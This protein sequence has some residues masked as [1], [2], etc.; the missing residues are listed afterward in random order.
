LTARL[1][2]NALSEKMIKDD[3]SRVEESATKSK[4]NWVLVLRDVRT[5]MRV[6]LLTL[7][8]APTTTKKRKHSN[9]PK[10]TTHQIQS[11]PS[12]LREK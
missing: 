5:R 4:Y 7:F 9:Q 6:V 3:L 8:L 10:S 1:Q 12:T 11:L 2:K